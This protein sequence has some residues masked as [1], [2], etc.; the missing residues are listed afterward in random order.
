M[1]SYLLSGHGSVHDRSLVNSVLKDEIVSKGY[2]LS[3][4]V[5]YLVLY[6]RFVDEICVS[7]F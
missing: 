5:V 4:I 2:F 7:L 6:D 3:R 1:I